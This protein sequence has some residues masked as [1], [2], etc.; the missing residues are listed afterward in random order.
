MTNYL[1]SAMLSA[2]ASCFGAIIEIEKNMSQAE[3]NTLIASKTMMSA[4]PTLMSALQ[5]SYQAQA[6]DQLISGE[7]AGIGSIGAGVTQLGLTLQGARAGET[8][9]N[10]ELE[11]N[12]LKATIEPVESETPQATVEGRNALEMDDQPARPAANDSTD[13]PQK[14]VQKDAAVKTG[15]EKTDEQIKKDKK[16]REQKRQNEIQKW[17]NFAQ[18]ASPFLNGVATAIKSPFDASITQKTGA[19]QAV[20]SVIQGNQTAQSS[21]ANLVQTYKDAFTNASQIL[22]GIVSAQNH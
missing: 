4:Q 10:E 5:N 15:E 13:A 7:I 8:A 1:S 21:N 9:Y 3:I 6:Q 22:A 17:Q 12:T 14:S 2:G 20:G 19:A 16:L 11:P 18:V